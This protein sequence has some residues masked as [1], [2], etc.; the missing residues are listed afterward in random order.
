MK[1]VVVLLK[2]FLIVW[3]SGR[4]AGLV[5]EGLANG[6]QTDALELPTSSWQLGSPTGLPFSFES[7]DED[8]G[9]SLGGCHHVTRT[10]NTSKECGTRV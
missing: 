6:E 5:W 9:S 7:L 4:K 8:E 2:V 10:R 3:M 1:T